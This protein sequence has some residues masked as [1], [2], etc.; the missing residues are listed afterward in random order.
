MANILITS[1][2]FGFFSEEGVNLLKNSRH[3]MIQ[4]PYGHK[5]L[6]PE[7]IIPHIHEADAIICDLEQIN[8]E[9]MDAAPNLKIIS[10]RGVGV[11]NVDMEAASSKGIKVARTVGVIEDS[12]AEL[13]MAYI[14]CF[15][16]RISEMNSKMQNHNWEKLPS[17][18]VIGKTLGIIG[19]GNIG[20]RLI[21]LAQAF[22]MRVLYYDTFRQEDLESDL[23]I[24]YSTMEELLAHSDYI[25]LHVPLNKDTYHLIDAASLARMRSTA[26]LI[27]AS[28]GAV[29]D[30]QALYKVLTEEKIAG[31][32]VDVFSREPETNSPLCGLTNAILTPHVATFTKPTFINMDVMAAQNVLDFFNEQE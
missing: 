9:V 27:N 21:S 1:E 31:A 12:V 29:V 26:Y 7:E 22:S 8:K 10:R 2:Y 16:R 4:N 15:G 11:D 6:L 19:M 30:D 32:A 3:K 23:K 25:T 14:L 20:R 28:R 13:V 24:T 18:G 17:E 5:F